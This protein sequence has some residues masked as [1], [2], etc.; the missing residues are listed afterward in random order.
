MLLQRFSSLCGI[1]FGSATGTPTLGFFSGNVPAATRG[2][3]HALSRRRLCL[4][5]TATAGAIATLQHNGRA[6]LR[7]CAQATRESRWLWKVAPTFALPVRSAKLLDNG[8]L[9]CFRV[10]YNERDAAPAPI[11]LKGTQHGIWR[12]KGDAMR[13]PQ[14]GLVPHFVPHLRR[15]PERCPRA[16]PGAKVSRPR[17]T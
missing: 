5:E 11:R 7:P 10:N 13:S 17:L 12:G 15:F 2:R 14:V 3:T 1:G 4:C 8:R 6:A 16:L 9:R